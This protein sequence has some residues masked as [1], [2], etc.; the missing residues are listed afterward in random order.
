MKEWSSQQGIAIYYG[1]FFSK[2]TID[3]I[4]KVQPSLGDGHP[5]LKM[6]EKGVSI[7]TCLPWM[8]HHIEAIRLRE[9]A[10]DESKQNR[11]LAEAIKLTASE[12][13]PPPGNMHELKLNI[14]KFLANYGLYLEKHATCPDFSA[15][16]S[17]SCN[18]RQAC[19][20][21]YPMSPD[22]VGYL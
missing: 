9:Q 7:L 5:T 20:Y 15:F 16:P 4:V 10:L 11:T 22:Y 18:G 2:D 19:I 17:T 21:T 8:Q 1:V 3:D 6:A 12:S 14:A 13:R